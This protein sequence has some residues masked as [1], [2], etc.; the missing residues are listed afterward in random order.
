MNVKVGDIL[1]IELNWKVS[2]FFEQVCILQIS[3]QSK[4]E[5]QINVSFICI[6]WTFTSFAM[7]YKRIFLKRNTT[8]IWHLHT[9]IWHRCSNILFYIYSNR[10]WSTFLY[11]S[12]HSWYLVVCTLSLDRRS[13]AFRRRLSNILWNS[14]RDCLIFLTFTKQCSFIMGHIRE[15]DISSSFYF[16]FLL[17]FL[18][19]R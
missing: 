7:D 14:T 17:S 16:F 13:F 9:H 18:T 19:G 5:N 10:F 8:R 12:S 6:A 4:W 11:C 2:F 15:K 3:I 1:E